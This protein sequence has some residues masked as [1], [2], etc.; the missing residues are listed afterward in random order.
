MPYVNPRRQTIVKVASVK[1]LLM[2]KP[3]LSISE[4][5]RLLKVCRRTYYDWCDRL[6]KLDVF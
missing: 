6:D 1:R 5:C 2:Q 4:A 3:Y